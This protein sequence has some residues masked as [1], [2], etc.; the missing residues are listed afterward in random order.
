MELLHQM[1]F[2]YMH[3]FNGPVYQEEIFLWEEL[4]NKK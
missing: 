2:M 1:W 4:K 3:D